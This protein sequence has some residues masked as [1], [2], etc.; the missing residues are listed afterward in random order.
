MKAMQTVLGVKMYNLGPEFTIWGQAKQN[1]HKQNNNNTNLTFAC[2]MFGFRL[3]YP[4]NMEV[5]KFYFNVVHN[6]KISTSVNNYSEI[7]IN[8]DVH[9]C[10]VQHLEAEEFSYE[11][12]RQGPELNKCKMLQNQEI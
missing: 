1:R 2:K 7:E 3:C 10:Y 8:F 6:P 11:T 4:L 9:L 12:D 5:K